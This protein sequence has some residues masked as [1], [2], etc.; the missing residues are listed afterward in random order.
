MLELHR[1]GHDRPELVRS[2]LEAAAN[3][4]LELRALERSLGEGHPLTAVRQPGIGGACA[5]CGTVHGS[6]DRYCSW[7]GRAL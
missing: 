1:F 2:K 3:T 7:C 4:D 5:A 6:P